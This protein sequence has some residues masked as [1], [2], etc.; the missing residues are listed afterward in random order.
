MSGTNEQTRSGSNGNGEGIIGIPDELRCKRSDGKQWRCTAMSMPDKTVCEKHYVQAKKRA[1][2]SASR[3]SQ[4][5][6]QRRSSPLLGGGE[7][8]TYSEGRV[9]DQ[10]QQQL[11][12]MMMP[13]SNGHHASGSS[14]YDG[15]G[16]VREKRHDKSMGSSRYVPDTP[17]VRNFS[18]RVAV[19]LNDEVAGDG[20]MFEESYRSYRTPPS[21]AAAMMD[22]SRERSHQS[23]SPMEYSAEEST[24]VSAESVGQT[25]HH[26]QRKDRERIISCLKCNQRAFCDACISTQYSEIS[27]EEVE[28][29]CP[30]CR[31]LCDCKHCLRSDNTIKVRMQAVPVLDKL[32]YLYRLLSSVL[33]VIK[34][35]HLDQCTELELEKRL[36]GAEI[37][38]VRARLKADDQMCCN[39]CQVPV[40]DY[41]R[42]CPNCSFDLCL[43]C[44]QDLRAESSVEIGV[45]SQTVGDRT[46]VPKLKLNFSYKFPEWEANSDGSIPCPPKEYGGCGSKSLNLARIFKMNWVAKLVKNAD[47]MVNGCKVS[48]ICSPELCD[49]RFC[50]LSERD[51][52]GDNF[53]YS[54]SLETVKFDGVATFEKQWSE[55][56]LVIVK[57]VLDESSSSRWDPETVWRDIEENSDEKL[58]EHDPFLKAI[59]CLDGL[60]VEVRLGEFIKAYGDGRN[61]ETGLSLSW[62]L[63]DWPSPSA[64]EEF[65]FNQRPEFIRRFPFLEY[66]H[67]RLGLLNV[68]AK[69]PHYS[70]QNDTGP[71]VIVSCGTFK[72]TDAGGSLNSIHYSMRDMVYLLVHTSEGTKLDRVR[73]TN[74]GPREPDEKMGENESLLSPEKKKMD[75]ELHD[76]SLG[77]AN[78]EKNESEM[79]CSVN[80]ESLKMESSCTSS[81]AGGA[82]WDVFRRQDVPKLAEYLQRTFLKPDDSIKC[83]VASRPLFE[84]LFLNEHHKTQLKDEL[85]IEPWTFEQLRGEAIFIPAG[86]PFQFRNLQSNVQVALDFLCPESVGESARLAEEIR[87]LPYD[88]KA[89]PQILEIGKISLYAAS[90][91]IKEVQKLILNPEFGAELGFEDPNLTKAVSNNL[92]KV[93]K[94][95][96]QISC[97]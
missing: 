57:K 96:Q 95:P 38:L 22:R 58:K 25:C 87:C 89:K 82:K 71:K 37:D 78:T 27:L 62:K 12:M 52:S 47:E 56:R 49:S 72:E 30:A 97:T 45:T 26:C 70:L 54:P 40:V 86:C 69:M 73:E 42:R 88:Q 75:G 67:P 21:A 16:G 65:I 31:G 2:N 55:G 53:V 68:A 50:K 5:K 14:K 3:A 64:S 11:V 29:V 9:D 66:I 8:D 61:Q 41:Y 93:I 1:A 85:G 34:Q 84:G 80:P 6:V 18:A 94:R 90:S 24:D 19:D 46:G 15:G 74:H 10:Q 81:C 44:C 7:T 83:D 23:M 92:D 51:E 91:A 59:N 4:R 28:K 77:T 33:P 36:R 76:L 63:K 48:E 13:S 35:I 32:K 20:G 43:R 60:E 17:V 79:M 39:V